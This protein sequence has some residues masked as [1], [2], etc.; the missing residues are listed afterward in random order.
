MLLEK[1]GKN[2]TRRKPAVGGYNCAGHVWASRRT[3]ILETEHWK[4]ILRDD[5]YRRLAGTEEPHVGD[6]ILYVDKADDKADDDYLHVAQ[7]VE[8]REGVTATSPQVPWVLSKWDSTSGEAIHNAYDVPYGRQEFTID[9]E[10][11]TD[12]PVE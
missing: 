5:G 2:W 10:Y 4:T 9:R 8:L 12:R 6:L 11:W 1:Y 7:I 3:A